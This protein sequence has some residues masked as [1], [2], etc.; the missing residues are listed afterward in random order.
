M[1]IDC[2]YRCR[3]GTCFY[4]RVSETKWIIDRVKHGAYI[5]VWGP[6]NVGKSELL[7]Y[8][9]WR[10]GRDG[11]LVIYIDCREHLSRDFISVY[12]F[13][14][15]SEVFREVMELLGLNR[16]SKALDLLYD[17]VRR[18]LVRGVVWVFDEVHWLRGYEGLLE[19]FA[20]KT[21]YSFYEKPLSTIVSSSEGWFILGRVARSIRDYGAR[22]LLVEPLDKEVFMEYINSVLEI[23]GVEL[24]LS[25]EEIYNEYTGG[26]PGYFLEL[27]SFNS[28]EEWIS[29]TRKLFIEKI[30]N[31]SVELG[32]TARDIL[33]VV[34]KTPFKIK[35]LGVERTLKRIIDKL[36]E[37]NILYYKLEDHMYSV[38]AQL[39]VYK[40]IALELLT[41]HSS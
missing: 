38:K 37:Y 13:R 16:F 25:P 14:G 26:N 1:F 3:S 40:R 23:R 12:G 34:V 22:D 4:D 21:I 27:L 2:S 41:K 9:S 30:D 11:F 10:L 8:V 7:R 31:A 28:L 35:A 19:V 6:R 18:V 20:K 29:H 39:P 17:V 15:S 33:E 5:L 32:I 36:M 24:S